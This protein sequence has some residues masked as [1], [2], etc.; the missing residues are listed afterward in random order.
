MPKRPCPV[1]GVFYLDGHCE[2]Q[3]DEA[4]HRPEGGL[5]RFVVPRDDDFDLKN[6]EITAR[7][8]P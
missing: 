7:T 3:R 5:D 8:P 1:R 2:E 6:L 4:V